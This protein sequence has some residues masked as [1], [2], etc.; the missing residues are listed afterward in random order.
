M[1]FKH[2]VAPSS[3]W[4][5]CW[6]LAERNHTGRIRGCLTSNVGIAALAHITHERFCCV[7]ELAAMPIFVTREAGFVK[8][9]SFVVAF[10]I[11]LTTHACLVTGCGKT[12]LE[13]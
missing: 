3:Y 6:T 12:M 11:R 2:E 10:E 5:N 4:A 1:V 9:F 13:H 8:G 7:R